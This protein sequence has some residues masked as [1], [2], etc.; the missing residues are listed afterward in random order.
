MAALEGQSLPIA[1]L[2]LPLL[3][4]LHVRRAQV[5]ERVG[6]LRTVIEGLLERGF[7]VERSI[8]LEQNVSFVQVSLN[9]VWFHGESRLVEVVC[10]LQTKRV[11]LDEVCQVVVDVDVTW[12][13]TE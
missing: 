12:S 3:P 7:C 5:E 10:L 9:E 13:Y 4:K 8:H 1:P 11:C 2:C 6:V